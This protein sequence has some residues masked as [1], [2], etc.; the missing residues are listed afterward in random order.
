MLLLT[1]GASG[2]MLVVLETGA[3]GGVLG[4]SE[5]EKH[6]ADVLMSCLRVASAVGKLAPVSVDGDAA[7]GVPRHAEQRTGASATR[8]CFPRQVRG[9][10]TRAPSRTCLRERAY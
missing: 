8:L 6:V 10:T 9:G 5:V 2:Q 7:S 3:T 1:M 4:M